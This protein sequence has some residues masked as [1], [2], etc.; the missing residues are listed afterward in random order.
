MNDR[1]RPDKVIKTSFSG[2]SCYNGFVDS[3]R[4]LTQSKKEAV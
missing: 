1:V 3:L 4:F 2:F